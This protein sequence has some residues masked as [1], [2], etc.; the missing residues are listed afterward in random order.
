MPLHPEYL[1]ERS[2]TFKHDDGSSSARAL[3]AW[4]HLD[5]YVLLGE[6]GAGKSTAFEQEARAIGLGARYVTARSL[7]T[8]GAPDGWTDEILFI[9]AL[10]ERRGDSSNF[11]SSL[12]ELGQKLNQL[13][14]PRFRLSC[15]E[16]DWYING[17][18]ELARVAPAGQVTT[19]WLDPLTFEDVE[20]LLG[21]WSPRRVADPQVFLQ[22]AQQHGMTP[23]LGNPLLLGMLVDAVSGNDWPGSR[24]ETYELACKK[25]AVEHNEIRRRSAASPPVLTQDTLAAAGLLC[26]LMLLS[27]AHGFTMDPNDDEKGVIP[28]ST[29][30]TEFAWSARATSECLNSK[31]FIA[32]GDRRVPR[33]RT[34]AE[35]LAAKALAQSIDRGLPVQRVL[36][37]MCG[38]DGRIVEPLRGLYAWLAVHCVRERAYLVDRDALGLVLYGD[39][40][41]FSVP[42]KRSILE[43]L[44]REGARF[45]WFRNENWDAHPFGALGTR[46]MEQTF[47]E[48]LTSTAREPAHQALLDCLADAIMQGEHALQLPKELERVARDS[49]YWPQVRR[50]TLDAWLSKGGYD[51]YAAKRLLEDIRT[52]AVADEDDQLLGMLLTALYPAHMSTAEALRYQRPRRQEFNITRFH[53]F[54]AIDFLRLIPKAELPA[55]A[56]AL[57]AR[58]ASEGRSS[59]EEGAT[60]ARD[61]TRELALKVV[62]AALRADTPG[63]S[64]ERLYTWLGVGVNE[65]G[66]FEAS[67]DEAQAIAEWL[68]SHPDQ[69]RLAFAYGLFQVVPET[70][71]GRRYFWVAEE[72]MFRSKRARNW[73][74]W[75][76]E[77]AG[78]TADPEVA[79]YCLQEAGR[80]AISEMQDSSITVE[81]IEDWVRLHR[82][83]WPLA[84]QWKT[85]VFAWPL[86]AYQGVDYA[87]RQKQR[88][89][90]AAERAERQ[91]QLAPHLAAISTGLANPRLLDQVV[92]A[93]AKRYTNIRG[94]T[95]LERVQDFLVVGPEQANRAI[96]GIKAALARADLPSVDDVASALA[97]GKIL[98][99]N[100]VCLLAAKL[101]HEEQ[102]DAWRS[103][104]APLV[105]TMLAFCLTGVDSESPSWYAA[106]ANERPQ[107]LAPILLRFAR[108]DLSRDTGPQ[109]QPLYML[110]DAGAPVELVRLV[111]PELW[112]ILPSRPSAGQLRFVDNVILPAS[113]LHLDQR[114]WHDLVE[115][116]LA[117]PGISEELAI[118]LH[119]A[120]MRFDVEVHCH[121]LLNLCEHNPECT[122]V[123]GDALTNLRRDEIALLTHSPESVGRLV[124][125]LASGLSSE[126]SAEAATF[127]PSDRRREAAQTLV[128]AIASDTSG[129]AGSE[130]R[131]LRELPAMSGW[132]VYLD[133]LLYDHER[134]ANRASFMAASPALVAQVLLNKA[135]ANARDMAE[136][137][138]DHLK[139]LAQRI[140]FE[141]SNWLENFYRP[142]AVGKTRKSGAGK[143]PQATKPKIENDCR[144]LVH[145]LLRDRVLPLNVQIE[146]ESYAAGDKRADLQA[147]TIAD[148][149]RIIVPIEV[150]KDDHPEVWAAW[151]NQLAARY[152]SNPAAEGIGVYLVLWFGHGSTRAPGGVKPTSA[153]Q[154]AGLLNALIPAE[155]RAHIVGLVIDLSRDLR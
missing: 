44:Y 105:D 117:E 18:A 130:L 32:D 106:L 145:G 122:N 63:L 28:F 144:D 39:V 20:S 141:E 31:L 88:S 123:L 24:N 76:L 65:Y 118:A 59:D 10:D 149:R 115:G 74:Q 29:L 84:E 64:A 14:R 33:H 56:D 8:L 133:S 72:R 79:Q 121:A 98:Y 86:D 50:A 83:Q 139:Q 120:A 135:P 113:M 58:L 138:R 132:A 95:P 69:R 77:I 66:S 68:S 137:V 134:V 112:Q 61:E 27:D 151:R 119:V 6:P 80:A 40:R 2:A 37:M 45:R 90:A 124:A 3:S 16:A 153:E 131:R 49:S 51:I 1:V 78:A 48:L 9:D 129:A 154:M 43:A 109:L 26:A 143:V 100:S 35:F 108:P 38:R 94:E 107:V 91:Q 75:L 147:T 92:N 36:A 23:L 62:A 99:L 46:D 41:H 87:R 110:R 89:K 34:I 60:R 155:R 101:A 54:W 126:Q 97:G 53:M 136:L 21:L 150:K 146:K 116:K 81:E 111:V 15:R 140:Q 104:P 71:D 127:T 70:R 42:E 47:R 22:R 13:G 11:L 142:A 152:T 19:L 82:A 67:G 102:P 55:T 96:E 114:Q 57:A 73:F 4:R 7:L 17:A 30:P 125:L 128:R 5:A 25:M 148:G 93:H 52:G 12:D 85:D 103:W